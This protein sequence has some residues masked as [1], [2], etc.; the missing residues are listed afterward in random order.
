M[1]FRVLLTHQL[2]DDVLEILCSSDLEVRV[3]IAWKE[4]SQQDLHNA[5][6]T[7]DAIIT[8][9][10]DRITA[11][12]LE[13]A[14]V[15]IIANY[16]V[17]YNNIDIMAAQNAGIIITNTPDVLTDASADLAFA[18]LMSVARRIPES[19]TY[20]RNGEFSSW[21]PLLMLGADIANQTL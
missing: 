14:C 4:L 12:M 9:L 6:H 3:D 19:D 16:A 17:G 7:Y 5:C 13:N 2:P 8:L 10:R 11:S 20:C 15:Q 18:L 21:D 1:G